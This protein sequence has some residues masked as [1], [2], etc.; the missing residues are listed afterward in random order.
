[1]RRGGAL[2]NSYIQLLNSIYNKLFYSF[3][4]EQIKNIISDNYWLMPKTPKFVLSKNDNTIPYITSKN[5][6]NGILNF[7]D[8]KYISKEDYKRI[9]KNREIKTN[10]ILISMIGTIGEIGVVKNTQFYGQ[11]MYLLRL[12]EKIINIKYFLIFISQDKIK[13]ILKDHKNNSPQQYLKKEFILELE[14]P[15]PSLEV[16]NKIVE[17]LDT[18]SDYSKNLKIGLPLEIEQRQKQ[19]KCYRDLLLKF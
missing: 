14:I 19:Y 4:V 6:K 7:K 5:I 17:I 1:M 3:E 11:N 8:S 12:N 15:I 16:Q 2:A 13:N 18:L 10:D 9:S